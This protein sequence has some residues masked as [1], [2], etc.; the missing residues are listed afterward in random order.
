MTKH[1]ENIY[2]QIQPLKQ[3]SLITNYEE[4]DYT[5]EIVVLGSLGLPTF[6][7]DTEHRCAAHKR[8]FKI[9]F[10]STLIYDENCSSIPLVNSFLAHPLNSVNH[11]QSPR[12]PIMFSFYSR[13]TF[14]ICGWESI[15]CAY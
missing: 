5:P 2:Q 14:S 7:H 9:I 12:Y 10:G 4:T 1:F 6:S 13:T 8:I 3:N 15:R 11:C